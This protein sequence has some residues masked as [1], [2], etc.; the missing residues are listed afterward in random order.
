MSSISS[1][2]LARSAPN[3]RRAAS[4]LASDPASEAVCEAAASAP[5]AERPTF[6]TTTGLR[7]LRAASSALNRAGRSLTP[8]M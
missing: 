7:A 4:K 5:T 3:R 6:I 8:S 2:V 1:V